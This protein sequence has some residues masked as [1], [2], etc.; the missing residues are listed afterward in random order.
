LVWFGLVWFGLDWFDL[1]WFGLVH[2]FNHSVTHVTI[3]TSITDYNI[4]IYIY[5]Y[6]T[7]QLIIYEHPHNI[8]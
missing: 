7:T 4:Y 3:D 6:I 2:L 1:V 5:I 8:I